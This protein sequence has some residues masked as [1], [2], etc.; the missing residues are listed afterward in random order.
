[1]RTNDPPSL[2]ILVEGIHPPNKGDTAIRFLRRIPKD[3][4]TGKDERRSL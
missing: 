2:E 4:F 1:L 3:P